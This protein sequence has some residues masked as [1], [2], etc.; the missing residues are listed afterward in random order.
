LNARGFVGIGVFAG[1]DGKA[2]AFGSGKSADASAVRLRKDESGAIGVGGCENGS[3]ETSLAGDAS[4]SSAV[5]TTI[6]SNWPERSRPESEAVWRRLDRKVAAATSDSVVFSWRSAKSDPTWT[7]ASDF[8]AA[9]GGCSNAAKTS[10]N[11][12]EIDDDTDVSATATGATVAAVATTGA[13]AGAN[14]TGKTGAAMRAGTGPGGATK[15]AA[16]GGT[17]S[18]HGDVLIDGASATADFAPC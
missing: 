10:R 11:A 18:G 3:G 7:G 14:E 6:A 1:S 8:A 5:A 12:L 13:T 16:G 15:E 2:D 17:A 9:A 4:A